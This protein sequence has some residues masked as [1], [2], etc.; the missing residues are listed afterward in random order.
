MCYGFTRRNIVRVCLDLK[1]MMDVSLLEKFVTYL[2]YKPF[3]E[4]KI[5][6]CV[7]Q[8]MSFITCKLFSPLIL[9][10]M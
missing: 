10:Q 5:I 1:W 3:L 6:L 7:D 2:A 9:I 4:S 8:G